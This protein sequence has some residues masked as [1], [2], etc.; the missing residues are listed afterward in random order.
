[1]PT[2]GKLIL[3]DF[4]ADNVLTQLFPTAADGAKIEGW[5][6]FE[7]GKTVAI[8]GDLFDFQFHA[9]PPLGNQQ[10]LVFVVPPD[11]KFVAPPGAPATKGVV[12]VDAKENFEPIETA[13]VHLLS[14]LRAAAMDFAER[15]VVRSDDNET[16]LPRYALG[17]AHYC[18]GETA[19]SEEV[20]SG[21]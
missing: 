3:F 21:N 8:P 14:L 13:S 12:R 15:G 16:N 19:C 1:M 6:I 2:E 9:A 20:E 4:N 18:I 10:I 7:E 11:A 17:Q 5:P